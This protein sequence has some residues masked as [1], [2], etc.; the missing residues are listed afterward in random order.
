MGIK[1]LLWM[2]I[3]KQHVIY[4][5][6]HSFKGYLHTLDGYIC[7]GYGG[8]FSNEI[9]LL[10]LLVNHGILTSKKVQHYVEPN[11]Y[12]FNMRI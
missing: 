2:V 9:I 8:K 10:K 4:T 3:D 1:V 6:D 7:H 5:F 11:L 12:H